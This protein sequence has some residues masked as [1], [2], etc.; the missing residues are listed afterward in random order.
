MTFLFT[1]LLVGQRLQEGDD[2]FLLRCCKTEIA[3][4]AGHVGRILGCG[5]AGAGYVAGVVK[6]DDVLKALE[7]AIVAISLHEAGIR[8]LVNIAKCRYLKF[9]EFRFVNRCDEASD[10]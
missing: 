10:L 4:L 8:S 3:Y 7:V 6:V 1:L 9:P 2:G 5:P